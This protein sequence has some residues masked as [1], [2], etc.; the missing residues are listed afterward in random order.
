MKTF[1]GIRA[2]LRA[3]V[4]GMVVLVLASGLAGIIGVA[5]AANTV[6]QLTEDVI[7]ASEA[8]SAVLR[9]VNDAAGGLRSWAVSGDDSEL[10]PY[11]VALADADADLARLETAV[12]SDGALGNDLAAQERAV[13]AWVRDYGDVRLER[14]AGTGVVDKQLFR[15]GSTRYAD[16]RTANARIQATLDGVSDAALARM[17]WQTPWTILLLV[18]VSL[19]AGVG[20]LAARATAAQISGP[21]VD[22]QRV[23]DK[24]ATG[25][26]DERAVPSGPRE[27][28]RV[29][30]ALNNFADENTRVREL[31]QQVVDQLTHLDRAKSDFLSSV[32]HELRTPL[33]SITGY[34]E[35]IEDELAD[36][37]RPDQ[38]AM[39]DVVKRNVT[40]LR[41]LIEDLLSLSHA[42]SEPFRTSFDLFDLTHVSSDVVYDLRTSA[43]KREIR[44]EEAYPDRP[45]VVRG[46]VSQIA[47]AMLNLVSNAIKF[48]PEG[49]TVTIRV[50]QREHPAPGFVHLE[51]VDRGI[52][53]PS[54]EMPQ[55]ATRFFRASNAVDAAI[56]GTGLGLR[57]VRAILDNHGGSLEVESVQGEGTTAR[58]VLPLASEEERKNPPDERVNDGVG[59]G[60]GLG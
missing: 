13:A 43:D 30:Y 33:T 47:R 1:K 59:E 60:A 4:V 22:L 27:V 40:R 56:A 17:E 51:V 44:V 39:M 50:E 37:L 48:S 28:R 16:V 25:D 2:Q 36:Q 7:P 34:V 58:M 9:D 57:I 31:E 3:L 14:P 35:L 29:A 41:A 42:E 32:S 10:G 53:I 24:W 5:V 45:V 11:R 52:G 38:V 55:L 23:V 21:L 20:I 54:E 8:N 49:S 18:A 26:V 15:V 46:D 12:G 19:L 6:D